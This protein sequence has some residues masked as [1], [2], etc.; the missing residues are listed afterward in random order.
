VAVQLKSARRIV[1]ISLARDAF[2]LCI[3][4]MITRVLSI[5]FVLLGFGLSRTAQPSD[6]I[7]AETITLES[8]QH[9]GALDAGSALALYRPD[10]FSTIDSTLL[11]HGLPA[12]TL[13]D[14]RRFPI[15]SDL[16]RMGH[17]AIDLVPVAFLRSVQVQKVGSSPRVGTEHPG[18]VVDLR[19]D[20]TYAGGEMGVFYGKSGG[21]YGRED[22]ATYII[23]GV[24]NDKFN[25]T[26]GAFYQESSGHAPRVGR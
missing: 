22:K 16:G 4:I 19:L 7:S 11:I 3:P 2:R 18:G 20:R 15:S 12:L 14:G 13:L 23:G 1:Q 25:I 24:G 5:A 9:T 17:T 10:L 26:A 21:K 6:Q 8:L